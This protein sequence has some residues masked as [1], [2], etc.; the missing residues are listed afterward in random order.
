MNRTATWTRRRWLGCSSVLLGCG[1]CGAF[2][3]PPAA[4]GPVLNRNHRAVAS[5][6]NPLRR[7]ARSRIAGTNVACRMQQEGGEDEL[8]LAVK[9]LA[10]QVQDLTAMVKQLAD[11]TTVATGGASKLI[12]GAAVENNA[13]VP[14]A[15]TTVPEGKG[16]S[17]G[18]T[19]LV[20]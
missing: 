12:N 3:P 19:E 13:A 2:L 7:G 15:P 4:R 18:P 17:A 16:K 9:T 1:L 20:R 8:Q 5:L 14:I 6:S 11:D 10:A